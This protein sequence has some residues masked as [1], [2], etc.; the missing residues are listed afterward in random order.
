MGTALLVALCLWPKAWMPKKDESA[1]RSLPHADK[2]VHFALFAS[3]AI[4]WMRTG[5]LE[6]RRTAMVAASVLVLA[7]GTEALQGL[8]V[9][10][11]DPDLL[12]CLADVLGGTF[13]VMLVHGAG[14]ALGIVD[15]D[16]DEEPGS[17]RSGLA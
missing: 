9:I 11:R 3:Y 7:I 17:D 15:E 1:G 14:G 6:R 8:P 2:V 16:G 12:D 4:L 13:G 10:G 5:P